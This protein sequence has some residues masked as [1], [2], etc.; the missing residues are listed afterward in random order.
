MSTNKIPTLITKEMLEEYVSDYDRTNMPE[1][2]YEFALSYMLEDLAEQAE[3]KSG[4][5]ASETSVSDALPEMSEDLMEDPLL[6]NAEAGLFI[7]NVGPQGPQGE[8]GDKGDKGD[9]GETGP[10][11]EKG[12]KGDK[13]DTG[14][15]GPQGVQ[16]PQ[17]EQGPQERLPSA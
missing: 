12:D 6:I 3:A 13:G 11:G 17:G 1:R 16:G 4:A 5:Q 15:T 10:Q 2:M 8:K 14:E 9:T 7:P